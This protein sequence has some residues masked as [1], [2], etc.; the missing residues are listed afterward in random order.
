[1]VARQHRPRSEGGEILLC[2]DCGQPLNFASDPLV[3]RRRLTN[4]L[5]LLALVLAGGVLIVTATLLDASNP[6][7]EPT[8]Q[9][10]GHHD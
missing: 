4:L 5:V 3:R 10:H 9:A 1:M 2:T 8:R 6:S 7:L